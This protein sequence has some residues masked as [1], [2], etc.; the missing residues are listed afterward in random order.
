M[1]AGGW[2]QPAE[3]SE[4]PEAKRRIK[5]LLDASRFI[6]QLDVIAPEPATDADILR[7]HTKDYL[8]TVKALSLAFGGRLGASAFIVGIGILA[9]C[10]RK[11]A[12]MR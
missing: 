6:S 1:F 11:G 5:N 4:N 9:A 10:L 8:A 7:V 12:P 3:A 2:I